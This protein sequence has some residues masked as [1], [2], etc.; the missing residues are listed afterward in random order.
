MKTMKS[1]KDYRDNPTSFER[2]SA[3]IRMFE[4]ISPVFFFIIRVENLDSY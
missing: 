4:Q 3:E 2:F 1:E